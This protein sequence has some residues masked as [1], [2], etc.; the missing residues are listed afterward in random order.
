M[1]TS[2]GRYLTRRHAL[3]GA[4]AAAAS[5]AT[6]CGA[7]NELTRLGRG[8]EQVML[9]DAAGATVRWG[10]LRGVPRAL[11]F[12]FTNCPVICPVTVYELTA[13]SDRIGSRARAMRIDFVTVDPERDTPDRMRAYFSGFGPQVR[14]FTGAPEMLQRVA[15]AFEITANRVALENGSYTMDHTATV[16]LLDRGGRV[17]D[18]LAYGSEAAVIEARIV[19][20]M[21]GHEAT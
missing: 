13:A 16:F 10:D 2:G 1:T 4:G 7:D 3:L 14:A 11:F 21:D 15:R 5:V 8:I 6:S 18:V 17:D 9:T 12:G 20:L 19:D